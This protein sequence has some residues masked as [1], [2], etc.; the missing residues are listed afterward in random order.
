MKNKLILSSILL[1]AIVSGQVAA[2]RQYVLEGFIGKAD[3]DNSVSGGQTISGFEGSHGVRFVVPLG[4][5]TG[6]ELGYADF[7]KVSDTFIDGFGDTINDSIDTESFNVGVRSEIPF[8]RIVSLTGRIGLSFWDFDF[9]R[10]DSGFPGEIFNA[11]DDGVDTYV[12]F[13]LQFD[14]E[15]NF[16]VAVE[17]MYLGFDAEL[18]G[19]STDQEIKNVALSVGYRF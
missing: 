1:F 6:L 19:V 10:Q 11:S 14:I 13:G 3:Q 5:V 17:Y 8:G 2:E 16:R 18:N 15:D 7:G 12:G 4:R 9:T